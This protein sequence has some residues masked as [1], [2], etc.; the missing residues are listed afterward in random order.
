MLR[1]SFA[2]MLSGYVGA[3]YEVA[4]AFNAPMP[5]TGNEDPGNG[6]LGAI[7]VLIAL[8]HRRTTGAAVSSRTRS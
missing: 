2:P 7:A 5:P 4:G 3:T 1:Q 8:L 6:M